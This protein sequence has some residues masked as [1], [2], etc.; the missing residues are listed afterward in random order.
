[1]SLLT[2]GRPNFVAK[3]ASLALGVLVR[4]AGIEAWVELAWCLKMCELAVRGRAIG[5][6]ATQGHGWV[7]ESAV[8]IRAVGEELAH[9]LCLVCRLYCRGR[10]ASSTLPVL[11]CCPKCAMI[12]GIDRGA[13]WGG[14][15]LMRI[16][17]IFP[18]AS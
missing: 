12:C 9:G 2:V 3:C 11:A 8:W 7:L 6:V 4:T 14:G 16:G 10:M 15:G 5:T 17:A 1:M 18:G 13:F